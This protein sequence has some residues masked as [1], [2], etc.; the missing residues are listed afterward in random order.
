M[1]CASSS[2]SE[3]W[4]KQR[5]AL[6]QRV[7]ALARH[8]S[9]DCTNPRIISF[10]GQEF[11]L[12][13]QSR[14][15]L[16]IRRAEPHSSSGDTCSVSRYSTHGSAFRLSAR[17][18]CSDVQ[19]KILHALHPQ[20]GWREMQ[21][22][23][24][25]GLRRQRRQGLELPVRG[26]AVST[27]TKGSELVA[28]RGATGFPGLGH[29]PINIHTFASAGS[30][31]MRNVSRST[32]LTVCFQAPFKPSTKLLHN[33]VHFRSEPKNPTTN[34]IE[35]CHCPGIASD[36][37]LWTRFSQGPR[38]FLPSSPSSVRLGIAALC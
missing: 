19:K 31:L 34:P 15:I 16:D 10:G 22:M 27:S 13:F 33:I 7:P 5:H 24:E 9:G 36:W 38:N 21:S 17:A 32:G 28:H 37:K 20:L 25:A 12:R 11:H 3:S 1:A 4:T 6:P 8:V 18:S 2:P 30:R 29:E 35:Q 14:E 23:E 26:G